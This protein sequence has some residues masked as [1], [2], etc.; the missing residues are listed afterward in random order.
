MAGAMM[1]KPF[2]GGLA[3]NERKDHGALAIESV[4]VPARLHLPLADGR[5]RLDPCVTVGQHLDKGAL[6]ATGPERLH[7]PTSGRVTDIVTLPA[8]H[9]SATPVPTLILESD[10]MDRAAEAAPP[11]DPKDLHADEIW[12]RIEAAGIVGLGGAGYPSHLKRGTTDSPSH[13]VINAVECEPWISADEA[14]MQ[15]A[16]DTIAEGVDCAIQALSPDHCLVAIDPR[17]TLANQRLSGALAARLDTRVSIVETAPRYPSGSERQL[18]EALTGSRLPVNE[19][20]AQ[21]G[22]VFLNVATAHAIAR[23]VTQRLPLIE[24]VM[25]IASSLPGDSSLGINRWVRI[26]HPLRLL[27]DAL[28]VTRSDSR[29]SVLTLRLGGPLTGRPV[30]LDTSVGKTTTGVFVEPGPMQSLPC[31]HCGD[32]IVAC[33]EGLRPDTLHRL[34][35]QHDWDGLGKANLDACIN[36]AACDAACPSRLPL[37]DQFRWAHAQLS[38]QTQAAQRAHRAKQRHATHQARELARSTDAMHHSEDRERRITARKGRSWV[39]PE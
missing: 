4:E 39:K 34:Q 20:P 21:H 10:G 38:A 14:L 2:S 31:I 29:S 8:P 27:V 32:C 35:Q 5:A 15:Y 9:P 3:I 19:R 18:Y 7:A 36:C 22:V 1:L 30:D 25:T 12:R 11:D 37:A 6:V 23:A 17:K 28:A 33:P 26:G 24:R 16:P 13:L